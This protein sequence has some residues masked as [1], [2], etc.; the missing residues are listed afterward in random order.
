[1]ADSKYKG[2]TPSEMEAWCEWRK[3]CSIWRVESPCPTRDEV[4]S[5][6]NDD[7][8][9]EERGEYFEYLKKKV[10]SAFKYRLR[11]FHRFQSPSENEV[12]SVFD[13]YMNGEK[14]KK[15]AAF[16]SGS[17]KDY[18]FFLIASGAD[19]SGVIQGKIFTPK[20]GYIREITKQYIFDNYGCVT[21]PR[22]GKQD[23]V[24]DEEE[25]K[26]KA[27][28]VLPKS[29]DA[30][31]LSEDAPAGSSLKDIIS[32]GRDGLPSETYDFSKFLS[33]LSREE[34]I[35]I[36]AKT[37]KMPMSSDAVLD[38]MH[39]KKSKSSELQ[40]KMF[41]ETRHP[42]RYPDS[43]FSKLADSGFRDVLI[44]D[45]GFAEQLKNAVISDLSA[46]KEFDSFLSAL[47]EYQG[48]EE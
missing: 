27:K 2:L 48:V 13:D 4:S 35:V 34:K 17:Y 7:K 33:S 22:G 30:L 15:T 36:L 26:K 31:L 11:Q 28:I 9:P 19:F 45:P 14:K 5:G 24:W 42:E 44:N 1:M 16:T 39:C 10:V 3:W 37:H 18:L 46:E 8:T 21:G 47:K 6:K 41:P 29:L 40:N 23:I 25:K 43:L 32:D 12:I 38:F 20:T